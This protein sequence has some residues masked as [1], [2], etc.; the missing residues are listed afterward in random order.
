ME[1][2][3]IDEGSA[4]GNLEESGGEETEIPRTLLHGLF[5]VSVYQFRQLSGPSSFNPRRGDDDGRTVL[6]G[7]FQ[8]KAEGKSDTRSPCQLVPPAPA[9]VVD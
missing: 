1:W 7:T 3:R 4:G 6:N 2:E 8:G 5:F 9:F